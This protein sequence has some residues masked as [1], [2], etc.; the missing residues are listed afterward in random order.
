MS[1]ATCCGL[2]K[3]DQKNLNDNNGLQQKVQN[4]LKYF[5][6][7]WTNNK[8]MII[9]IKIPE[10]FHGNSIILIQAGKQKCVS[11]ECLREKSIELKTDNYN[12][13]HWVTRCIKDGKTSFGNEE[14]LS[15]FLNI[16]KIATYGFFRVNNSELYLLTIANLNIEYDASN[17]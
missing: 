7:I 11:V 5:V 14:E 4:K 13:D 3:L 15:V 2:K 1:W 17:R 6:K 9:A 12:Q 16:V 10:S 8:P